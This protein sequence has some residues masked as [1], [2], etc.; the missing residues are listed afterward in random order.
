MRDAE[1]VS[2]RDSFAFI[3]S[4]FLQW[5]FLHFL[6]VEACHLDWVIFLFLSCLLVSST[7]GE[8]LGGLVIKNLP[9]MQETQVWSLGREGLLEK[10]MTTHSSI[11]AWKIPWTEEPG[12]LQRTHSNLNFL[13]FFFNT[14]GTW[15]S[16]LCKGHAN[17]LYCSNFSICSPQVL[18]RLSFLLSCF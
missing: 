18:V 10:E 7:F 15:V 14:S 5:H 12:R 16:S 13:S 11:P 3:L 2:N 8:I 4:S 17:C 9:A 6:S 1:G